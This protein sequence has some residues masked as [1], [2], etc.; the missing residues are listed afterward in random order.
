MTLA[1]CF[2]TVAPYYNLGLVIIVFILF[3]QLFQTPKKRKLMHWKLLFG[4]VCLFV[5]EE[6]LTIL[7][8]AGLID[9]PLWINPLLE[10]GMIIQ[11]IYMLLHQQRLVS[12]HYRSKKR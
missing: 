2:G 5:I 8:F 4:A 3:L 9:Y 7:K 11:F 6:L 10:T 12:K 1:A